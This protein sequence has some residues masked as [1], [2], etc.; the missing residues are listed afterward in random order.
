MTPQKIALNAPSSNLGLFK[1]HFFRRILIE[2]P[3]ISKNKSKLELPG[4]VLIDLK[5][6]K[7][8]KMRKNRDFRLLLT[9]NRNFTYQDQFK[10]TNIVHKS[11]RSYSNVQNSERPFSISIVHKSPN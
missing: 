3:R 5:A 9:E 2:H 8:R 11:C 7:V 1:Y 4:W 10:S 6:T